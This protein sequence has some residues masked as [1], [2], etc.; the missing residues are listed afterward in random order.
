MDSRSLGTSLFVI[1]LMGLG[2]GFLA[3]RRSNYIPKVNQVQHGYAIPS[4]LEIKLQ[5]LDGD[6]EKETIIRYDGNSS[7]LKV[8]SLG[9]L[10]VD[11]YEVKPA[12]IIPR[13][14]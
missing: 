14:K 6:G 9:N 4:K 12:E 2:G 10:R 13:N 8:D 11:S 1:G 7:L 5:D 3:S